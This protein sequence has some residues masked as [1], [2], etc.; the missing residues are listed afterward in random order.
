MVDGVKHG[1]VFE[2]DPVHDGD[3]RPIKGMGRFEHEAVAVNPKTG[4][5][6]SPRTPAT[7]SATCTGTAAATPGPGAATSTRAATS[8]P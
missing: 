3:P 2:V 5:S 8:P 4:A 6:S 7:R 1:Y